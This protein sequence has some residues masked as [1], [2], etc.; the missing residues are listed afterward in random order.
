MITIHEKIP[1]VSVKMSEVSE[2]RSSFTLT[3]KHKSL[4]N[5]GLL[6]QKGK[7]NKNSPGHTT[8][9]GIRLNIPSL[10]TNISCRQ[11][12]GTQTVSYQGQT[13]KCWKQHSYTNDVL[14]PW[15][16]NTLSSASWE[17]EILVALRS[18]RNSSFTMDGGTS[19]T[20]KDAY[21]T[22]NKFIK[23]RF[24][25]TVFLYNRKKNRLTLTDT[26]TN[27]FH[28]RKTS[29]LLH[30]FKPPIQLILYSA[31]KRFYFSSTFLPFFLLINMEKYMS[32]VHC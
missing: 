13:R 20:F 18:W 6:A 14:L 25:L 8:I 2:P 3:R 22:K 21:N 32:L 7:G 9:S 4:V 27:L 24:T 19:L 1:S 17:Y 30:S 11:W 29:V 26:Q 16:L 28:T 15:A 5:N 12:P 31:H 10:S 23:D